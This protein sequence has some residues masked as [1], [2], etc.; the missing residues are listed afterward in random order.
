MQL[1]QTLLYHQRASRMRASSRAKSSMWVLCVCVCVC[2]C[3]GGRAGQVESCTSQHRERDESSLRRRYVDNGDFV[4][5]YVE[6]WDLE[7]LCVCGMSDVWMCGC[8]DGS[9]NRMW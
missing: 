9:Y 4:F 8:Y 3:G 2:V 5:A 1:K 6:V 7:I